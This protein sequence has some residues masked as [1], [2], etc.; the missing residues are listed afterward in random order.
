MRAWTRRSGRPRTLA[1][2]R[3]WVYRTVKA[4]DL[5]K[6]IMD[7]TYDHAEPGVFFVD[8]ANADNNLSY[9]EKIEAT[10]PCGE[11]PL[12]PYGCC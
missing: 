3:A 2:R 4:R 6:Q 11:Q 8:R 7:A 10:N 9:V 5:W 1:T 12:P